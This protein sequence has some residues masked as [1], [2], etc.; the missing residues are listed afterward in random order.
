[1]R[2]FAFTSQF[3]PHEDVKVEERKIKQSLKKF[4]AVTIFP[5]ASSQLEELDR[6]AAY[7]HEVKKKHPWT[8][9]LIR[10]AA[11]TLGREPV[12]TAAPYPC[13][14]SL[15]SRE[16][17]IPTLVFGPCGAG[18]HNKD[19]YVVVKSVLKTA[20][21]FLAAALSGAHET[22]FIDAANSSS[23]AKLAPKWMVSGEVTLKDASNIPISIA[24]EKWLPITAPWADGLTLRGSPEARPDITPARSASPAPAVEKPL[25][26][27]QADCS[28]A[29]FECMCALCSNADHNANVWLHLLKNRC[30]IRKKRC[31]FFEEYS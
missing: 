27:V 1:M 13:D 11:L 8:Q 3:L 20:E 30:A 19:E 2:R 31:V 26:R 14:A 24:E 9:C 23:L 16:Y 28:S 17:G 29:V 7:G 6:S 25:W 22:C 4:C 18:A 21:V 10:S 15:L 5:H 12:V